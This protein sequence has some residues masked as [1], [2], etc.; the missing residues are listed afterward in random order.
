MEA[1]VVTGFTVIG[2]IV[3]VNFILTLA[4]IKKMQAQAAFSR[5]GTGH[6]D[7]LKQ[8]EP[9]PQFTAEKLS[10]ETVTL[11]DY[12]GQHTAFIFVSPACGPCRTAIP[13]YEALVP[14]ARL[15]NTEL[16]LVSTA[17]ADQTQAFVNELNITM[18]VI[19]APRATNNFQE[20]YR[21][22][23]TP[24]YCLVDVQGAVVSSGYPSFDG[25]P[26]KALVDKWV[27]AP[28]LHA[29]LVASRGGGT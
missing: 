26:W 7:P 12:S 24:S 19:V 15:S 22:S 1:F 3:L 4:I 10:G 25:G 8:G 5:E 6:P 2:I 16:V 28:K 27:P 9:A 14:K 11:A 20:D 17:D 29:D 23:A 13:R 18:P 21:L